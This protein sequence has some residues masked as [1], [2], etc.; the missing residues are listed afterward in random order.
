VLFLELLW[1]RN[2]VEC[3]EAR[4]R[5]KRG[6]LNGNQKIIRERISRKLVGVGVVG[7]LELLGNGVQ[8]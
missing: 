4:L 7:L 6:I 3:I 2:L 1:S 5:K 8:R